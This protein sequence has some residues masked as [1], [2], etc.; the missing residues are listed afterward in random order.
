MLTINNPTVWRQLQRMLAE[1]VKNEVLPVEGWSMNS[2]PR[3][4][5]TPAARQR[6]QQPQ[7]KNWEA[8]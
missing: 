4:L 2:H 7:Q 1:Q 3:N 8:R 6:I 5:V